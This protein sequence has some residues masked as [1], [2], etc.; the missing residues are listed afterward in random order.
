[1]PSYGIDLGTTYSAI[2]C[3]D[4][5]GTAT[6]IN[7]IT[8]DSLTPSVVY[9]ES[10]HNVVVG[11]DAVDNIPPSERDKVADAEYIKRMMHCTSKD[12]DQFFH[13]EGKVK[14]PTFLSSLVLKKLIEDARNAGHNVQDVV[15]T[16]PA[17]FNQTA[18]QHTKDAA[19]LAGMDAN[20][21]R[22]ITE[23]AAAALYYAKSDPASAGQTILVYDLGGGTFDVTIMK[24]SQDRRKAEQ[25][26]VDGNPLLGGKDWDYRLLRRYAKELGFEDSELDQKAWNKRFE[27][28]CSAVAGQE[29]MDIFFAG[30]GKVIEDDKRALSKTDKKTRNLNLGTSRSSLVITRQEFDDIT[31]DLLEQTFA[32]TKSVLEEANVP[33]GCCLLV[34]GSTFMPQVKKGLQERFGSKLGEIKE[35]QPNLA[36]VL[37]AAYCAAGMEYTEVLPH[38]YGL[39]CYDPSIGS[40]YISNLALKQTAFPVKVESNGFSM[41]GPSSRAPLAVYESD[42]TL[43]RLDNIDTQELLVEQA[44]DFGRIVT[45][46]ERISFVLEISKDGLLELWGRLPNVPD[47]YIKHR[48]AGDLDDEAKQ[49]RQ[50]IAALTIVKN[51]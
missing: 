20:K 33:V 10:E 11:R 8:G 30:L 31:E 34:G 9:F 16:C 32:F 45:P 26:H 49:E 37:G 2:A 19:V 1:M 12:S 51:Y 43:E 44:W 47:A 17:Y 39:R 4:N 38:S 22:I 18:K 35:F 29:E 46:D 28:H 27:Q 3:V 14:D 15:I 41:V 6:V 24:I 36:V 23:P 25:I 13:Y 42:T 40:Q 5:S 50:E 7:N 21:V 48:L